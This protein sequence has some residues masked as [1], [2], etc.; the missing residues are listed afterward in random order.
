MIG[1]QTD[2]RLRRHGLG[3]H[4]VGLLIHQLLERGIAPVYATD[5][6]NVPSMRIA[7]TFFQRHTDLQFL[8]VGPWKLRRP[9]DASDGLP[10]SLFLS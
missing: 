10:D 3:R 1:V 5:V 9:K 7:K 2:A 8:F 4:A 6:A